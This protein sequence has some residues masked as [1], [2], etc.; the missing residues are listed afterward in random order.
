MAPDAGGNLVG[1]QLGPYRIHKQIGVGGMGEVYLALDQSLDRNVAIKTLQGTYARDPEWVERFR[2]EARAAAR[3]NHPN[4]V[5]I[6]TVD[7]DSNPPYM[8]MEFIDGMG[9]DRRIAS[10]KPIPWQHAL[11]VCQ[12][13]AAA[14]NAAHAQGIVHRDIKPGNIMIDRSGRIRVTDFGIAKITGAASRLTTDRITLGSPNYMSPEQCGAGTIGP[15]SDLFSLGITMFEMMTGSLPFDAETALGIIKQITQD[16]LPDIHDLA[17]DVPVIVRALVQKLTAKELKDRYQSA[18]E[19][20]EDVACIRAGSQ[21]K[22]LDGW[23]SKFAVALTPE[24]A[25]VTVGTGVPG[26]L[27]LADDLLESTGIKYPRY[28]NVDSPSFPWKWLV[29]ACVVVAVVAVAVATARNR[30]GRSQPTGAT[31]QAAPAIQQATPEQGP[32]QSQ[33]P[34]LQPPP[35]FPPPVPVAG[36]TDPGLHPPPGTPPPFGPGAGRFGPPGSR[37]LRGPQG[38]GL[39]PEQRRR[40]RQGQ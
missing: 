40:L 24:N 32:P 5:Q 29:A 22:H 30:A 21:P 33:P 14:L 39:T 2:R 16:P 12:Q 1:K 6:H 35:L 36:Q 3:L 26:G 31:R 4:I 38:E 13:V 8:A 25:S 19:V 11:V 7:V 27:S 17:P 37:P 9:L 34:L 10:G 15:Q 20:I 28:S 18:A 23:A